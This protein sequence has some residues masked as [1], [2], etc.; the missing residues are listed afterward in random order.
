[1]A[2]GGWLD[3]SSSRLSSLCRSGRTSKAEGG[4]RPGGAVDGGGSAGV[5]GTV[6]GRDARAEADA[7][8]VAAAD[9]GR[10]KECVRLCAATG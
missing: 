5:A 6:G 10:W 3:V 9:I 4:G 7:K 8:D 1:M 2:A